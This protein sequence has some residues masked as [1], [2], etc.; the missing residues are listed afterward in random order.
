MK[1]SSFGTVDGREAALYTFENE[2]LCVS[3]ADFGATLVSITVKGARPVD[4]LL[5]HRSAEEYNR[6]EGYFGATVGRVANRIAGARFTL[7]GSEYRLFANDKGYNCLHGGRRGFSHHFFEAEELPCG[8]RFSRRSPDGEEGFPGALDF[9]VSFTLDG[10]RLAIDYEYRADRRTVVALTNHAY[11]NLN[12][13]GSILGHRLWLAAPQYCRVTPEQAPILPPRP[14]A[15][16]VFDFTKEKTVGS[17]ME[18]NE[19]FAVTR[20][21]DHP[22]LLGAHSGPAARLTGDESGIVMTVETDM[23][24]IQVYAGNF[25]GGLT[26]RQGE[27]LGDYAGICLETQYLPNGVNLGLTESVA[28]PGRLYHSRTAYVFEAGR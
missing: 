6:Q 4:V 3:A 17:A 25:T 20:F 26:G 11:F 18:S 19:Q 24:G 10:D 13:G 16:T 5:G 28:E 21:L 23:P 27:T 1:K 8:V 2:R 14:V 7:D 15:G 22:Y 12:G 9:S